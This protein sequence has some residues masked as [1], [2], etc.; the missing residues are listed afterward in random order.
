VDAY[1][2]SMTGYGLAEWADALGGR[3]ES[4]WDAPLI[5]LLLWTASPIIL[6]GVLLLFR[7]FTRHW[8]SSNLLRQDRNAYDAVWRQVC[9]GDPQEATASI[10][11]LWR[12]ADA[13]TALAP[14]GP[15]PVL[16][17]RHCGGCLSWASRPE[18]ESVEL[19]F[20]QAAVVAAYLRQHVQVCVFV[21]LLEAA[22][23][24]EQSAKKI[25]NQTAS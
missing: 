18:V 24:A 17:Q 1:F 13:A 25:F 14:P 6:A 5:F 12:V 19:I 4:E 22:T 9:G 10:E 11:S 3:L 20:G 23:V 15:P 7:R 2:A 16:L 21:I 8:V